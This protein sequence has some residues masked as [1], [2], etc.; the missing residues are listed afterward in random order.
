MPT[1]GIQQYKQAHYQVAS[2]F[3]QSGLSGLAMDTYTGGSRSIQDAWALEMMNQKTDARRKMG[4]LMH[5][6]G[7]GRVGTCTASTTGTSIVMADYTDL[8]IIEVGAELIIRHLTTGALLGGQTAGVSLIVTAKSNSLSTSPTL[9]VANKDGSSLSLSTGSSSYGVY[10]YDS[11]GYSMIGIEG[12]CGE[13]NP[14][15]WGS[16]TRYYGDIDRTTTGNEFWKGY[17][18]NAGSVAIDV[19][20]HL[21][22]ALDKIHERAGA[23]NGGDD[24]LLGVCRYGNF[25]SVGNQLSK[26]QRTDGRPQTVTGGYE[27]VQYE[28]LILVLDRDCDKSV[29]RIVNPKTKFRYVVRDWFWDDRTGAIWKEMTNSTD[30]RPTDDFRAKMFSRQQMLSVRNTSD[31]EITALSANN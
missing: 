3:Q 28:N 30:S 31:A 10:F 6:N 11:Q 21:Q 19:V 24:K 8:S 23:D 26:D 17:T 9:T 5:K 12:Y 1:P 15:D 20:D 25:R 13:A 27:A 29:L 14:A 7:S 16:T 22:V 4:W 2:L 18:L